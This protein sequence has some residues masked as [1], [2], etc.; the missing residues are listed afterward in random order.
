M[1]PAPSG[2]CPSEARM[3]P[4]ESRIEKGGLSPLKTT[5]A[6][7]M[8]SSNTPAAQKAKQ[9]PAAR[10]KAAEKQKAA[11]QQAKTPPKPAAKAPDKKIT[12]I[13]PNAPVKLPAAPGSV[14]AP[15]PVP[16]APS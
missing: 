9:P 16:N 2:S 8:A 10:G 13:K 6:K 4:R 12:S 11:A 5:A 15:V 7:A 14:A 3:A 1:A